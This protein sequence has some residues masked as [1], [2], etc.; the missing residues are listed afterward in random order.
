MFKYV[1]A[2]IILGSIVVTYFGYQSAHRG[3]RKIF[4]DV[5]VV[6]NQY[7]VFLKKEGLKNSYIFHKKKPGHWRTL[8]EISRK[9]IGAI[10]TAED[11][12]F[13][14]HNGYDPEAIREA[15]KHNSL[16]GIRV[17]RG[18]STITQQVVKNLFLFPEKTISRKIR[19]ILLAVEVERLVSKN[20]I[21][22]IYLNIAEWGPGIYGIEQAS[23]HYF[24]KSAQDLTAKEG[25]VLAF[26]LPNPRRYQHSFKNGELSIFGTNRVDTILERMWKTG[27][28]SDEEY[29]SA[30]NESE[31]DD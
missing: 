31:I 10:L 19:E 15:I 29:L 18:G 6:Q 24:N 13:Y 17:K 28:I 22:E 3:Y 23:E 16:P 4:P 20:K 21:L 14:K 8:H 2:F 11:G 1:I 12:N 25:A 27:R 26:L 9:A 30:S 7:P 5:Q